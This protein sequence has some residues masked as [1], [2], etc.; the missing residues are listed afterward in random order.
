MVGASLVVL[1][2]FAALTID[3]GYIYAVRADLQNTADAASLAAASALPGDPVEARRRALEYVGRQYN[4]ARPDVRDSDVVLG[5]WDKDAEKFIVLNGSDEFSADAARVTAQMSE[6]RNNPL[7]LFI[8]GIF[9]KQHTDVSASATATFGTGEPWNVVIVQ[10]VTGSFRNEID[11]AKLANQALL[12]C[13]HDHTS[14]DSLVGLV[15][16]TGFGMTLTMPERIEDSYA[17]LS[18]SIS[19]IQG[20]GQPGMPKCSGTNIGAGIDQAANLMQSFGTKYPPA[21][22]LVSDGMPNSSRSNPGYTNSDLEKWAVSAADN[23]DAAGIS[24]FTLFYGGNDTSQTAADF[25]SGLARGSGTA[26]YTLDPNE[27]SNALGEMCRQGLPLQLV[28]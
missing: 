16:F 14:G 5:R 11:E 6:E 3:V 26:H 28:E 22:M 25:L 4:M 9:G 24:V 27:L 13:I 17:S 19:D 21:I 2:G 7:G 18:Q 10:D 12:D 1:L 8:A 15:A 20:C 23:A